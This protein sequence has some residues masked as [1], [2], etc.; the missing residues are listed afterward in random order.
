[1]SEEKNARSR[2]TFNQLKLIK[3]FEIFTNNI[4]LIHK[5]IYRLKSDVMSRCGLKAN[6]GIYLTYLMLY[7]NGLTVSELSEITGIDK[8]SVSRAYSHLFKN[9]FIEYPDFNGKRKYN[10]RAVVTEEAKRM[11]IPVIDTI[12]ELIDKISLTDIDEINRTIMYRSLR[13]TAGNVAKCLEKY[14]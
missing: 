2:L 1:M 8:A 11:M 3:R 10:T 9:G 6:H 13:T 14:D 7:R 5:D 4:T 12:C